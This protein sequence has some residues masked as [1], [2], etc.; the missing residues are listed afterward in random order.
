MQYTVIIKNLDDDDFV[1]SV[2]GKYNGGEQT[3]LIKFSIRNC[4][5]LAL[6]K[7]PVNCIYI[8]EM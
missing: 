7:D 8:I 6:S 2:R 4:E 3:P 1:V 5:K